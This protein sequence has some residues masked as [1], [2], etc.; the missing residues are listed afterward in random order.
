MHV[1]YQGH[2]KH[3]YYLISHAGLRGFTG[4]QVTVIA[5]VVSYHRKTKPEDDD[6]NFTQ[7]SR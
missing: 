2:H 4:D 5:N 3:S 6:R 1:S 7:L